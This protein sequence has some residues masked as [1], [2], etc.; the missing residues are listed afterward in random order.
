MARNKMSIYTWD[1]GMRPVQMITLLNHH[2]AKWEHLYPP[3][4]KYGNVYIVA[5]PSLNLPGRMHYVVL[6]TTDDVL[7]VLDPQ[8][9]VKGKRYYTNDT[10]LSWAGVVQIL[11]WKDFQEKT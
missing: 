3:E 6:D 10:F 8:T 7:E 2:G 11:N 9:K 1:C 5:T 4:L